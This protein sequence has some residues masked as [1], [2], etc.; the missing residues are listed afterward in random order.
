MNDDAT[1]LQRLLLLALAEDVGQGDLTSLATINPESQGSAVIRAKQDLVLA[2]V[3][4]L[5]PLWELVDP[6]TVIEM[7]AANGDRLKPKDSVAIVT[8]RVRS[9]L[10]GE[11]VCLNLLCHLSGIATL[12]ARF[13]EAVEGHR[14]KILDTRK[15]TPGIR[16]LEKTAVKAGGGTNHRMGLYDQILIKD[17]HIDASGGVGAAVR[18]AKAYQDGILIE[19]EVRNEDE[20][21]EAIEAGADIALLDNMNLEQVRRCVELA[22]NRL[23]LEVSGGVTLEKAPVLAATGVDRISIGALTHSAPAADLHMKLKKT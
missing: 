3:E 19:V 12:T 15:T 17:N 20:L 18:K 22:D 7:H 2:G 13:V 21:R 23:Q 11:R 8:G 16:H 4:I 10:A 1:H 5:Q 14:A 9:L 6:E